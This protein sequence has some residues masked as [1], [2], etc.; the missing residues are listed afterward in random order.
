MSGG[1]KISAEER[2][3]RAE[4]SARD[5]AAFQNKQ[6]TTKRSGKKPPSKRQPG[7]PRPAKAPR[8]AG[9]HHSQVARQH[10]LQGDDRASRLLKMVML[11]GQ[12]NPLRL[13]TVQPEMTALHKFRTFGSITSTNDPPA[14]ANVST[15]EQLP[16]D[17]ILIFRDP[18]YPV[19]FRY[20]LPSNTSLT[21]AQYVSWT[22]TDSG[23][24]L[25][26]YP[27]AE[28]ALPLIQGH[29]F[30]R[31]FAG[32]N[33]LLLPGDIPLGITPDNDR[34]WVYVPAGMT[35]M[36]TL[37]CASAS[38]SGGTWKATCM[39]SVDGQVADAVRLVA[40]SFGG[41]TANI[42]FALPTGGC[43][44]YR[45]ETVTN[46]AAPTTPN[47]L[48]VT[49]I[50]VG[51][52]TSNSLTSPVQA[53]T[54]GMSLVYPWPG[55]TAPEFAKAPTL[56]ERCRVSASSLLLSNTKATAYAEGTIRAYQLRATGRDVFN[57]LTLLARSEASVGVASR[58]MWSGKAAKGLYTFTTPQM[59]SGDLL[60]VANPSGME[61]PVP[62][63]FFS[64]NTHEWFYTVV[65]DTSTGAT[66]AQEFQLTYDMHL[67]SVTD[68]QLWPVATSRLSLDQARTL[69]AALMEVKPFTENPVHI[70]SLM[71]AAIGIMI[72]LARAGAPFLNPL[73]HHA[74]DYILPVL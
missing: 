62:T 53:S 52:T 26:T 20:V 14:I 2:Q 19:W 22:F 68:S 34:V 67:E 42:S 31:S 16:V 5:K 50:Q 45:W 47:N 24:Y 40:T 33:S 43:G 29:S 63:P 65:I 27:G 4:Q 36:L 49:G 60:D 30:S 18:V 35:P 9:K 11:P 10:N 25:P 15:Y 13:P 41:A 66:S 12:V 74:I 17:G 32:A 72:S 38:M 61:G 57:S 46:I 70:A 59:T 56:Y 6:G 54:A 39:R 51:W 1:K 44:W 55:A 64:L 28:L 73:A 8:P 3:R 69:Q 58:L 37:T 48:V 21:F 71:K 23:I 7:P